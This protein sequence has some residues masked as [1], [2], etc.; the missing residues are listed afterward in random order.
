MR[1][2]TG[3]WNRRGSNGRFVASKPLDVQLT[4]VG[5]GSGWVHPHVAAGAEPQLPVADDPLGD[6]EGVS[7][8]AVFGQ[9]LVW[10]STHGGSGSIHARQEPRLCGRVTV[11]PRGTH[12]ENGSATARTALVMKCEELCTFQEL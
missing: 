3:S 12:I 5:P 7:H 6:A 8:N 10:S 2:A 9:L 1:S 4:S 11:A